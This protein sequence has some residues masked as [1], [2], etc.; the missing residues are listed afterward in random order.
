M[1]LKLGL[2]FYIVLSLPLSPCLAGLH[3]VEEQN[4]DRFIQSLYSHEKGK[5]LPMP[6]RLAEISRL[7]LNKPY[8]LG[9]LGEGLSGNYD[10]YPL[11]R[12]DA[13]DCLT[14]VETVLALSLADNL[15]SF[16]HNM[17]SIRYAEGRLSFV[18]RNHFT[19]LDWNSN[20]Q[21][22]GILN[23]ITTTFHDEHQQPIAKTARAEINK[24]AWY[25]HFSESKIRL[26]VSSPALQRKR[27]EELKK[28]GQ[29]LRAQ[30]ATIY[31]I[32]LTVLFDRK[33]KPNHY[34]FQQIPDGAI[35]EIIRPNWDLTS[36]IGTHLNVSHLGFAFWHKGVLLFRNASTLKGSVVDQPLIE[37]LSD[38]LSSPTIKGIN[39]QVVL[40]KRTTARPAE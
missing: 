8:Y 4:A 25:Q 18:M 22:Q 12:V 11:Y 19:D 10:Q 29:N 5:T 31:Y 1:R 36:V 14:F 35:V 7:F 15:S 30:V 28:R 34:I 32:P 2:L 38:A 24:P 3:S 26:T 33:G 20:S 9:A 40:D 6:K 21:R 17:Q 27:L 37:Y 39:I 16:K 13:F 23:D